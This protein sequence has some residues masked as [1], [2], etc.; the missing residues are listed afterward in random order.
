MLRAFTGSA[1]S[2]LLRLQAFHLGAWR[3]LRTLKVWDGSVWR[4][5][6]NFIPALS[7]AVSGP[8]YASGASGLVTTNTVTATP[9]GGQAP[10]TYAWAR[11]SSSGP[12]TPVAANPTSATTAFRGQVGAEAIFRVI[13]TDA[14]G[15]TVTRTVPATFEY[16]S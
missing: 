15:S 7:V 1:W 9:S 14:L 5:I 16:F 8:A 13:V 4:V 6:G 10:Y 2:P 11:L 12:G 3:Q